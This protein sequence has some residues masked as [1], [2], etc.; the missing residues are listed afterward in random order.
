MRSTLLGRG[1]PRPV[2]QPLHVMVRT[3]DAGQVTGG[4]VD[5]PH[6]DVKRCQSTPR[7]A[8]AAS[9]SQTDAPIDRQDFA[10]DERSTRAGQEYDRWAQLVGQPIAA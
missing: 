1:A 2:R 5:G 6:A 10:R 9:L 7:A 3:P 4:R 8:Q